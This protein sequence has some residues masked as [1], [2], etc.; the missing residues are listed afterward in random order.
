MK[1]F[2]CYCQKCRAANVPG[3]DACAQC[4]TPLM[5]IVTPPASRNEMI[6]SDASS[7]EHLLERISLLEL[8]LMQVTDRLS[9][10][11]DLMMRQS[12]TAQKE[13]LQIETLIDALT[14]AGV[15]EGGKLSHS[16]REKKKSEDQE[17]DAVENRLEQISENILANTKGTKLDLFTHL[18]KDGFR[19]INDGDEK[20]GVRTL[21]R[22]SALEQSNAPLLSF[23][24]VYYFRTDK[25][26][27]AR[28][29][30]EKAHLIS[31]IQ[32]RISL[33]LGVIM[34]DEGEFDRA[35]TLLEPLC[36]TKSFTAN[37]VVGMIYATENRLHETL[38]S[39]KRALSAL[40]NAET[41]YLVGSTCAEIG[42]EKTAL[43]HLQK[44]VELDSNFADAWFMLG[45]V[46]LRVGDEQG[47]K[48]ALNQSLSA[49]DLTA[50]SQ[51]ILRNPKK[52]AE[53][54]NTTLIFARLAQVKKNLIRSSSP[55][56]VKLLREDIEA[57]VFDA[58]TK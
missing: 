48:E 50:Q 28:E 45:A 43:R 17:Q 52:Y 46:Y 25:R 38:T 40:P 41:H 27:L 11:L 57:N 8:R 5:L 31:P 15:I 3:E 33:L 34:T 12:K 51:A 42:R 6:W 49:R 20:Q 23:I 54:A 37:Y 10:A 53:I 21:E 56:L 13:H 35:K 30:L 32:K 24:G 22:A 18:V 1:S 29:Y 2:A 26:A 16:W 39:F 36:E 4:G 14:S 44:A 9:Q 58:E 19:L 47:A 7:H 55:R